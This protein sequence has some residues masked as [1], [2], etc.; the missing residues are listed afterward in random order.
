MPAL[1]CPE[2]GRT[3]RYQKG[4][5]F[6]PHPGTRTVLCPASGRKVA[7]TVHGQPC[8]RCGERK[9]V[10]VEHN[11]EHAVCNLCFDDLDRA[12][13]WAWLGGAPYG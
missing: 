12:K 6:V 13:A 4:K 5:G 1:Y 8:E 10:R 11:G 3:V 7:A 9:A 2:C